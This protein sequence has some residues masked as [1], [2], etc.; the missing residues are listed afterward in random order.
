MLFMLYN[1]VRSGLAREEYQCVVVGVGVRSR[2][3]V[4][5]RLHG[6]V[7]GKVKQKRFRPKRSLPAIHRVTASLNVGAVAID[8]T[9]RLLGARNFLRASHHGKA[10]VYCPASSTPR[11]GHF[12]RGLASRLRLL[13]TRT[14]FRNVALASFLRFYRET[15]GRVRMATG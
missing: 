7:I 9:C 12:S 5:L 1:V 6:R 14:G 10:A 13:D 15:F 8:G 2:I 4:C 11:S 3:P